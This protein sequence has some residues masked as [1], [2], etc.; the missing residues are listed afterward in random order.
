[1]VHVVRA[2]D[3]VDISASAGVSF[4]MDAPF[5]G[6]IMLGSC[7]ARW[8]EAAGTQTTTAGVASIEVGG[9]EYA[10]LTS[11]KNEAIGD[12]DVFTLSGVGVDKAVYVA[13]GDLIDVKLKTQAVGGTVTG[14]IRVYLCFEFADV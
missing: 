13:A 7:W 2:E 6:K 4:T 14:T 5:A 10:T 9:T 12:R 1:M 3:L 11:G 8:E